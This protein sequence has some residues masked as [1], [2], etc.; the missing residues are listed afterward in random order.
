MGE[1][2][3]EVAVY[4]QSGNTGA[5]LPTRVEGRFPPPQHGKTRSERQFDAN[6]CGEGNADSGSWAEEIAQC[7]S[8]NKQLPA[9][10]DRHGARWRWGRRGDVRG[11]IHGN[12]QSADIADVVISWIVAIEK[13]EKFYEGRERPPLMEFDGTAHAQ[14]SLHIGRPPELVERG[15]HAIDHYTIARG[16]R[17]RDG[18][19]R[20]P[21]RKERHIKA[22][23][24]VNGSC[25][26][27]AMANVFPGGPIISGRESVER[28][29]DTIHIIKEFADL[30]S[31]R[32]RA[33]DRL[34]S[35]QLQPRRHVPLQ[36]HCTN[37]LT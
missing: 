1:I 8:G 27:K 37:F 9:A 30:A 34:I 16:S 17:Q 26:N 10:G 14:I 29:A 25:Q 7:A 3:T 4:L 21:L 2:T 5:C 24:D 23:W 19:G 13:I 11:I 6:L 36:M 31:P 33:R 20:L 35:T 15:L 28:I 18:P 22:R 32:F 12:R